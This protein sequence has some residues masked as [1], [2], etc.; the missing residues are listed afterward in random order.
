M[1]NK[2]EG[3]PY[4]DPKATHLKY[5][6]L[7]W[8]LV[9][10][11]CAWAAH[12]NLKNHAFMLA[13]PLVRL[14]MGLDVLDL[15]LSLA[16]FVGFFGWQKYSYYTVMAWIALQFVTGLLPVAL[17]ARYA[18]AVFSEFL[19]SLVF[20]LIWSIPSVIYYRKRKGLFFR[21]AAE[22]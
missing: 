1:E 11:W 10:P 13:G 15:L 9:L 3:V 7:I 17:Y 4:L 18:P 22:N 16:L 8:F 5:H 14:G 19:I 12:F 20:Y 6:Y 21:K 2:T